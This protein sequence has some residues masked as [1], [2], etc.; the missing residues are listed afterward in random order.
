MLGLKVIRLLLSLVAM[1]TA[2][3]TVAAAS[4]PARDEK[5]SQSGWWWTQEWAAERAAFLAFGDDYYWTV[6][7]AG[8]GQRR[9]YSKR[10]LAVGPGGDSVGQATRPKPAWKFQRFRCLHRQGG[11]WTDFEL[12]VRG[13]YAFAVAPP[14]GTGYRV[15]KTVIYGE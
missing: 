15:T 14:R 4:A 7:C 2:L 1:A 11:G 12:L 6:G 3:I 8:V 10:V 5:P 9:Y 13:D